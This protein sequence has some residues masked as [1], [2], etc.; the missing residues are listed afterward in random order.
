MASMV[1]KSFSVPTSAVKSILK[2]IQNMEFYLRTGYGD[3][4]GFA[5]RFD[6]SFGDNRKTQGMCQG[7]GATPAAWTVTS[8]P[9]ITAQ[10]RKDYGAHLI[11]PISSQQGHLIGGLFVEDTNLSHLEMCRNEKNSKPPQNSKTALSTGEN[12]SLQLVAL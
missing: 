10:C 9:M 2:T 11:A 3:F 4:K 7:N 12:Y 6:N 8:V 5:G 1:F